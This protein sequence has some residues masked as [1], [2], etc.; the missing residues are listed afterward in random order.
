MKYG[1]II[2]NRKCIGCHACTTACK[3]EHDVPVG[4]F[5]TWV[6]QVEKGEFPHTRRLFSVMRCNHCTDAPCVEICPV[7]A[8]YFRDDGIVDFDKDRCIGCKSCMQAC[9]YDAL[10]IDPENH[11]AAKCNY[12]AHRIDVGLEPA[13]VNVCPE[14]AIISGDMEDPLSEISMLLG[15]EQVSV[16]KAAKGT[17]PNLFYIDG[18]EASLNPV[19]TERQSNYFWN[20]QTR[21]VGH[22]AKQTEKLAFSGGSMVNT[23]LEKT[24]NGVAAGDLAKG[25]PAKSIDLL[26]GQPRRVYD[27]PVKGILWGWEVS[28]YVVTKAVAAGVVLVALM[29]AL[30]RLSYVSDTTL[31]WALG[32]GLVFLMATGALLVKDL[33]RPDRFLNV[34]LRPQW[35]SWLVRGGYTITVFGGLM[36]LLA[37]LMFFNLKGGFT[38][39]LYTLTLAAATMTAVYTA[40]L[41]AQAK[42]RDFWQSPSLAMHMLVHSFMAGA[43]VFMMVNLITNEGIVWTDY[44]RTTLI[45]GLLVNLALMVLEFTTT[46]PTQEAKLTVQMIL[47]GRYKNLFWAGAVLVGNILPLAMLL[48]GKDPMLCAGAGV[49]VMIGMYITEKIWVEAPQRVQLV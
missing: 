47:K 31:W 38:P 27:A 45:V 12:C 49:L 8:L 7:E 16:R 44:L 6:K 3:S 34:L 46:H 30:F 26:I 42:G 20:E 39:V 17:A 41:F 35:G 11:T 9:P 29:G 5:R 32:L 24:G 23:L 2:D 36:A 33:D 28:A 15:R 37:A 22:F 25:T 1:F 48:L 10:Y 14:H 21:G 18:D 43:A 13:C 40:F 19:A 4:V